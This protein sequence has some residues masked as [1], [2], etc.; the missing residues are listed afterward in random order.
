MY[1]PCAE[2]ATPVRSAQR[3]RFRFSLAPNYSLTGTSSTGTFAALITWGVT[4]PSQNGF[5]SGL[6][7][8]TK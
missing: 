6:S 8:S 4:L 5:A 1:I 7:S 3:G 2:N